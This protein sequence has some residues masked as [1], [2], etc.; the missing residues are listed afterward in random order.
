VC[1]QVGASYILQLLYEQATSM[2]LH[3]CAEHSR[4]FAA[5]QVARQHLP[6]PQN[7][8]SMPRALTPKLALHPKCAPWKQSR[9]TCKH[10][11]LRFS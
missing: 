8:S 4:F 9:S 6:A 2:K 10:I 7:R 5:T 11:L 1:M 3:D